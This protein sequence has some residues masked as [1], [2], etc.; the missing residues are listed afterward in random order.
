MKTTIFGATGLLG[1]ALQKTCPYDALLLSSKD[2]DLR[3]KI[4]NIIVK[5]NDLWINTA[6]KVGGVAANTNFVGE[7]YNDNISM[8]SNVFEAAKNCNVKKMISVLS[9]CIYPDQRFVTYPITEDQLHNGPPHQS[10]FGYA[11]A[12]RMIDVSSRAYRQQWGCNYVSVVPNNLYGPYDNYDVNNGH[13]IPSLIR[14]FFEAKR[15]GRDVIIWGT[16]KP[17]REFTF[18]EDAAQ[19][20]WWVAKNYD[21]PDPINIGNTEEISISD[22]AELIGKILS[23]NGK[24]KFDATKPDGQYR[25]PTSNAKLISKGCKPEYTSL[26]KGL[27]ISIEYFVNN[28]PNVRGI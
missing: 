3:Q 28:Y 12:K 5:N 26:Q 27:E 15:D 21:E 17:L 2:V 25:K 19:I 4:D 6:A 8:T 16:G 18:S 23:Y 22:L 14:K 24:I 20:M 9:T 11:Y 10:N 7:F 1:K 13:V